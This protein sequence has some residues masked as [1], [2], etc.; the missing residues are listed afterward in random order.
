MDKVTTDVLAALNNHQR[1]AEAIRSTAKL[2]VSVPDKMSD[3]ELAEHF[4][5]SFIKKLVG[6]ELCDMP[7][8][9]FIARDGIYN[10]LWN[11]FTS[12]V[13]WLELGG[14]Y[15]DEAREDQEG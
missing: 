15:I 4:G 3:R 11:T 1:T 7:T 6:S 14:F 5:Q 9:G 8:G 12:Q 13:N 10:L 2:L